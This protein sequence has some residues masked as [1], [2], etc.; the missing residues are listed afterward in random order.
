MS[1]DM[2]PIENYE[3]RKRA[4]LLQQDAKLGKKDKTREI[5]YAEVLRMRE[6]GISTKQIAEIKKKDRRTIDRYIVKAKKLK[7]KGSDSG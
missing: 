5:M 4:H 7:E 3:K 2:L 6:M 1:K